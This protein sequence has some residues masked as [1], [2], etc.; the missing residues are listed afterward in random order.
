MKNY[1]LAT[2]LLCG[3][4]VALTPT[5]NLAQAIARAE[6]YYSPKTI[7]ARCFNPGDLKAVRGWKYPGQVGVCKGGHVRF[8]SPEAGWAALYH[9]LDRIAAGESRVYW[10]NMTLQDVTRKYAGNSRVWARSV[11]H[12]LGVPANTTLAEILDVPPV[13]RA[14]SNAHG[15]DGIMPPVKQARTVWFGEC[16]VGY[17]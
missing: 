14:A 12:N 5:Q 8:R 10:V 7:P 4:A 13:L 11:A 2:L 3:P 1:L 6:G 16:S 15:L 17:L 9:K